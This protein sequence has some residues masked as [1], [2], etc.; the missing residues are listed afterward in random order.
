MASDIES[1]DRKIAQLE[2]QKAELL[3]NTRAQCTACKR[4][5]A[6]KNLTY[7]QTHWYVEPHGCTEGGYWK[8]GEGR[9][10]CPG[11][12]HNNRL[13]DRKEVEA[14]KWHFGAIKDT[15]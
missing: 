15:Y 11:C 3:R 10:D 12:G 2:A 5:Y 8:M 14:L 4:R 7:I 6:V 9:F 13:Y 1:I